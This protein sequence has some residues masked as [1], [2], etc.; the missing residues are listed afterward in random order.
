MKKLK[1][2]S[3]VELKNVKGGLSNLQPT[4]DYVCCWI[5][6]NNCSNP[7]HHDHTTG[8]GG[9]LRCVPGAELRPV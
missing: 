7:V 5:G 3:I 9:D 8:N 1:K 2:L 6:T 4:G